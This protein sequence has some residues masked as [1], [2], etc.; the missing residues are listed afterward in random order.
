[1]AFKIISPKLVTF[2]QKWLHSIG[3]STGGTF[4]CFLSWWQKEKQ[5]YYHIFTQYVFYPHN[6][7]QKLIRFFIHKPLTFHKLD[8]LFN[9]LD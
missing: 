7:N 1:M 6:W 4:V 2:D 3:K 9:D 5:K 8:V